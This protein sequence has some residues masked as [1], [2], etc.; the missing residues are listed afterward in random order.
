MV[1]PI[2]LQ[3]LLPPFSKCFLRAFSKTD[4]WEKLSEF[5][6]RSKNVFLTWF[7]RTGQLPRLL[8]VYHMH[9]T[10]AAQCHVSVRLQISSEGKALRET[11]GTQSGWNNEPG[12]WEQAAMVWCQSADAHMTHNT[13]DPRFALR[14]A[15]ISCDEQLQIPAESENGNDAGSFAAAMHVR[16]YRRLAILGI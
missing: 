16:M 6:K 9:S 4:T 2:T 11:V 5:R 10:V 13:A 7:L 8:S 15:L 1:Y 3:V 12:R 14:Q